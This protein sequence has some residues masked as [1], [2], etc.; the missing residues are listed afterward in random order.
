MI[1][2]EIY[3]AFSESVLETGN[4]T[5]GERGV[6][7]EVLYSRYTNNTHIRNCHIYPVQNCKSWFGQ[8]CMKPL[9][10]VFSKQATPPGASMV[11]LESWYILIKP[12]NTHIR[13]CQIYHVQKCD[14]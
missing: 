13:N 1:L 3:A 8:K 5:W 12:K 9:Q 11:A 4:S 14:S 6:V 10:R 7:G 2:S